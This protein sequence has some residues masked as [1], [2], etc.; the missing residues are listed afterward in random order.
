M[1]WEALGAIGE[2]MGAITVVATLIYLSIQVRHS[3]AAV[4][5]NTRVARISV[6]EQHTEAQSRWRGRLAENRDLSGIWVAASKGVEHLD[7]V[8]TLMFQQHCIDYFNV[9]RS[10]YVAANSVGH[11]GQMAHIIL[12]CANML[13]RHR[14]FHEAWGVGIEYSKLVAPEFVIAV[15]EKSK[16]VAPE[17]VIAVEE[18]LATGG[19]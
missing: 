16:L 2:I 3:K 12:G 17:F 14:G 4:E 6:L 7:E 15:E 13:S 1:N 8:E 10:S 19:L 11:E 18:K 5:E 9:W